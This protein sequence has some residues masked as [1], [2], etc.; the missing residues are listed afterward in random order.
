VGDPSSGDWVLEKLGT[1]GSHKLPARPNEGNFYFNTVTGKQGPALKDVEAGLADLMI[2]KGT[3][4]DLKGDVQWPENLWRM[5]HRLTEDE[6]VNN[7][8]TIRLKVGEAQ[9]FK[10]KP[11]WLKPIWNDLLQP[12]MQRN[13][14]LPYIYG[15]PWYISGRMVV[16]ISVNFYNNRTG[17]D[18]TFEF[19]KDTAGDN[20]FVNLI[21]NNKQPILAT[22]WVVDTRTMKAA[23]KQ[24]M[25]LFT[26]SDE[27]MDAINNTRTSIGAGQLRPKGLTKI[28]GGVETGEAGFV[29]WV[30]EL[31]WHSTPFAG[32]REDHVRTQNNLALLRDPAKYRVLDDDTY[33]WIREALKSLR[34]VAGTAI[35]ALGKAGPGS[36]EDQIN[37]YIDAIVE[38]NGSPKHPGWDR[39]LAD[40][41]ANWRLIMPGVSRG[42]EQA[43]DPSN[44]NVSIERFTDIGKLRR[45][46]SI[47]A[48]N[49]G[50]GASSLIDAAVTTEPRSFVR[51]WVQIHHKDYPLV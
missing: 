1:P 2:V 28:E 49:G 41:N 29:S 45:R 6:S 20:L 31:I 47:I 33:W 23:K 19:H 30:D 22:E 35:K 16:D 7:L 38:N 15:Q 26:G 24:Q 8:G 4:R 27:L 46:N 18:R 9:S 50:A 48:G 32:S 3:L 21:F 17:S 39:H 37:S 5:L 40:I 51:T 44:T 13:G 36:W 34:R 12:F 14:Q 43:A 42:E 11:V 10:G 25:R